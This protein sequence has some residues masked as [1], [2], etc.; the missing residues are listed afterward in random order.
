[1][2]ISK[3]IIASLVAVIMVM[4]SMLT[5][6]VFAD[7]IVF[8]DV[9][10]DY[11][12]RNAIYS[13]VDQGVING[14]LDEA[15]G[16]LNFKPDATITRA[17]FAKM[18]AVKLVGDISLL[19]EKTTIFP[20]VSED[21]WANTCI[22]Y[23]VKMGIVNG[24]PDGT[25]RPNNP[26]TY[27]E[28]IKML[29]CAKGYGSIYQESNPWYQGY[30]KIATDIN[31]TKNAYSNG[32]L[33]ASRGLVA[34]LVYNMD[35][36]KKIDI[37]TDDGLNFG[38]DDE[39]EIEEESGVVMGVFDQTLTG[40]SMGL[41]KF[42]L[43]IGSEVYEIPEKASIESYYSYLGRMVDIE[44]ID[45]RT[46]VL[47]SILPSA[48]NKTL[49]ISSEDIYSVDADEIEY[50]DKDDD[51]ES[52]KLN[53]TM[54]VFYN[55]TVVPQVQIDDTFIETYFDVENGEIKLLNNNGGSDYEVAWI[56]SYKTYF[57]TG[58]TASRDNYTFTDSYIGESVTLVNNDDDYVAY[59]VSNVGGSK[60]Q[61]A[62]S[63][64]TSSKVVLSVAAPL[65]S[66]V[67]EAIVS[68]ITL[69]NAS[70]QSMSGYE[71]IIIDGDEYELSGYYMD[72]IER[73]EGTYGF[74]VGDVCT[75]YLDYEGKIVFVA[76]AE[77]TDPYG[78]LVSYRATT[79]GFDSEAAVM[80]VD[81]TGKA[82][83]YPLKDRV[84]LN[85]TTRDSSDLGT[86][87][88]ETASEING[89]RDIEN[90][91]YSQVIKYATTTQGGQE[92]VSEIYTIDEYITHGTF[93]DGSTKL[94]CKSASGN[95]RTFVNAS[96]STQFTIN[97]STLVLLI[98]EDRLD[99]DEYKKR[100][101]TNFYQDS[102]Y[103]IEAYDISTSKS[104]KLVLVYLGEGES[105]AANV[106][107]A[108]EVRFIN[109]IST[110]INDEDVR[111]NKVEYYTAGSTSISEMNTADL[112]V[113]AGIQPGDLVKFAIEDNEIV[114]VQKVFVG[115]VL[116]DY[117][118]SAP[119]VT[120]VA[121]GLVIEHASGT[122]TDYYRVIHG[123]VDSLDVDSKE[124]NIVAQ[125]VDDNDE[126][127]SGIG[128]EP[129]SVSS[130]KFYDF[131]EG[132]FITDITLGSLTPANNGTTVDAVN[133]SKVV[134][135]KRGNNY[136]AVYLV[137]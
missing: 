21:Y 26:V 134:V 56:T 90:G 27:G 121:D 52:A 58:R 131:D 5:V 39:E 36:T 38:G 10:E 3:R 29:V 86:Y 44:Y 77:S 101:Q 53:S 116:Y 100:S 133:A 25:F 83:E 13:L 105:T 70:V 23:A 98:P 2:K 43:K 31:L 64:I 20:D 110:T 78:Y 88:A 15:T 4:A 55:G 125:I 47:K 123:T 6:N 128:F 7:E 80:I 85:G 135:I 115:G 120:D 37:T 14:I 65:S 59:K 106:N 34:Q 9:A 104:A 16:I 112:N 72:L 54:Y 35:Y 113:M 117:D 68:G 111:V 8:P 67:T 87:L 93:Y 12:Y 118:D 99:T 76:K 17:E 127:D 73:D 60:Q 95:I 94:K 81:N 30:I 69:K 79:S 103:A 28:A 62:V 84:K 24:L 126:Y 46:K 92:Y 61:V 57:V 48:K 122:D 19:T 129:I 74:G 41:N 63:T 107:A 40:S 136:V 22:A 66:G 51:I 91:E 102:Y 50:Y 108:T 89:D 1:M 42:Q 119:L 124:L 114:A 11:A 71:E 33:P 137:D 32:E 132:E 45:G 96:G 82:K 97:A 75:F 49:T 109:E 18:V 130:A